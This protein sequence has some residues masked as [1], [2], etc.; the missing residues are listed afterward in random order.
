MLAA[1]ITAPK[2]TR[3]IETDVPTPGPRDLLIRVHRCGI[4]GTDIHILHGTYQ[5]TYPVTPGHEFAGVVEAAGDEVRYFQVGDR[6][7]ADPNVF[8]G[9]CENCKRGQPN[10]C[11]DWR[12]IG[13][14]R[15]GAFAEYVLVPEENAFPIGDMPFEQAAFIEPLACVVWGIHVVHPHVGDRAL[16]FGAGPMGC[17]V[18]QNL[19]A[20]GV[21][22]VTMVDRVEGRLATARALGADRTLHADEVTPEAMRRIAPLGFEIVADATGIPA[23]IDQTFAYARARGT[24]WLFGVAPTDA[25]ARFNPYEVFRRDLRIVGSY[26]VNKT[27][28]ESIALLQSG[29][30][31][32]A[33]LLSHSLPLSDFEEGMRIAEHEPDRMKV[34]FALE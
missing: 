15:P 22:E 32:V 33:P 20:A 23:V 9:R 31:T 24:V 10:Q 13:I 6:V 16:V 21:T 27:F 28:Y 29:A 30:V 25:T 5:A 19:K 4:C 26:A 14:T 17:L 11:L 3:L 34:Q 1:E 8:C 2:Q 18:M 7:T 12:G